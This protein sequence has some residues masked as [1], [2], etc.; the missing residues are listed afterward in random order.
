MAALLDAA[1]AFVFPYREIEASGVFYLV[2]G[3]GAG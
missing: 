1:D 3:S 2:Q